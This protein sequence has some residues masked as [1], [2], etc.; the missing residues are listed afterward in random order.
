[1]RTPTALALLF[2]TLAPAALVLAP[3]AAPAAVPVCGGQPRCHVVARADVNGDGRLD[4][5]ALV[6]RGADGA[7]HGSATVRVQ[8]SPSR[9]GEV[10]R[11]TFQWSG[12]L[13]LGAA[14]IDGRPGRELVLG[15]SAGVHARYYWV[16]AWRNGSLATLRTPERD[17]TWGIDS[18]GSGI[19]GWQRSDADPPGLIR[20][21]VVDPQPSGR[22]RGRET[23][24]RWS[25]SGWSRVSSR[26]V[27]RVSERRLGPWFGWHVPGLGLF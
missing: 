17:R 5:V 21:R 9:V 25:T 22:L 16:L 2:S 1:M 3:T 13:W 7:E 4:T 6:R 14:T 20:R 19:L 27:D 12:P 26:V 18:A 23:T 24:Y 8:T 11:G 15:A 10:T